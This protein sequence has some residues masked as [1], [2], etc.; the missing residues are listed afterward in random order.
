MPFV[1]SPRAVILFAL[2]APSPQAFIL[3]F[4]LYSKFARDGAEVSTRARIRGRAHAGHMSPHAHAW[5]QTRIAMHTGTR[6]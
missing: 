5:T 6:T 2:S 3:E 1:V 4:D